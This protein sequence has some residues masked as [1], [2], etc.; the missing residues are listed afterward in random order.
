MDL[1]QSFPEP[2]GITA[3]TTSGFPE[4]TEAVSERVPSP[5]KTAIPPYPESTALLVIERVVSGPVVIP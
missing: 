2:P 3:R 1:A 4:R 5:P